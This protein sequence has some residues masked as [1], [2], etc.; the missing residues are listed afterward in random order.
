MRRVTS[1]LVPRS[2]RS[3]SLTSSKASQPNSI[4]LQWQTCPTVVTIGNTTLL[5]FPVHFLCTFCVQFNNLLFTPLDY[6]SLGFWVIWSCQAYPID[7]KI[8]FLQIKSIVFSAYNIMQSHIHSNTIIT[9]LASTFCSWPP[10][11][12]ISVW[13][14][15]LTCTRQHIFKFKHKP[16]TQTNNTFVCTTVTPRIL[17]LNFFFSLLAK[18]RAL[19]FPFLFPFAKP[20]PFPKF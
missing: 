2:R 19:P 10:L 1:N 5:A 17:Q 13:S 16:I 9:F 20:W 7:C 18:I 8:Q 14:C 4:L 6:S 11:S 3:S 15:K 12:F